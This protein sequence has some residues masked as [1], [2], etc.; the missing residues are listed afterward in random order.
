MD[1]IKIIKQGKTDKGREYIVVRYH[2]DTRSS[3]MI[4][5]FGLL[6]EP[7]WGGSLM[8]DDEHQGYYLKVLYKRDKPLKSIK[9]IKYFYDWL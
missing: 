2:G 9:S 6:Y 8:S 1:A 4:E 7:S 3:D 5:K